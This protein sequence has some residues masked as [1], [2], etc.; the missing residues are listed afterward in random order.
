MRFLG[1]ILLLQHGESLTEAYW[2]PSESGSPSSLARSRPLPVEDR[3]LLLEA[4]QLFR[5][6]GLRGRSGLAQAGLE[7]EAHS[8]SGQTLLQLTLLDGESRILEAEALL[9]EARP[10]CICL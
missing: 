9:R 10:E 2:R 3:A 7:T 8:A 1:E 6:S 4:E 5:S